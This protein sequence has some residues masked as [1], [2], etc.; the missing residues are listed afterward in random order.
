MARRPSRPSFTANMIW[1]SVPEMEFSSFIAF[2]LVA[3]VQTGTPGPSTLFLVNNALAVGPRRALVAL[4]GDLAAIALL[5]TLSVLGMGAL[6][7]AYPVAFLVLRL[8]GAA[9]VIWLGWTYLR[10]PPP[11]YG[12]TALPQRSG[13]A[14]WTHSFGIGISNPKAVLFF[15]ALFPQFLPE[16]GGPSL[17]ALL[18]VTFVIVKF[19]ILGGYALGARQAVKLLHKPE[20][21]RRGRMLTGLIF[22]AFGALMIWAALSAL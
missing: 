8:L 2:I 16:D 17:M 14:L 4:S 22:I 1:G 12:G 11:Q 20:H 19:F 3:A 18:V 7:A 13:A 5:A 21:A 9:Y 10:S 15:A 6:L